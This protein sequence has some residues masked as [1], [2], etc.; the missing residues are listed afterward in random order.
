MCT[1]TEGSILI[2]D[3]FNH[4]I[5]TILRNGSVRTLAGSG[6]SGESNGGYADSADP[7]Q[8]RFYLPHGIA[9]IV[10]NGQRLIIIGGQY[11]HRVRVIYANNTVSTLAGS[12]GTGEGTAAS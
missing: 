8:A 4:R 10:E 2:C 3:D 6:G 9:S 1:H 12:G 5:R 7:L 11:D